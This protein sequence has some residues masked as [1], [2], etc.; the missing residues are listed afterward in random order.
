MKKSGMI[1]GT[2]KDNQFL[3]L[4]APGNSQQGLYPKNHPAEQDWGGHARCH[5]SGY[6]AVAHPDP[7]WFLEFRSFTERG[8]F[9]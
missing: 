3:H 1:Q 6:V 7:D 9:S 8:V 4:L 5:V 2:M